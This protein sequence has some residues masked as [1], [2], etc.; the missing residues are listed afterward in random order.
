MIIDEA[1]I[2]E[3]GQELY[4]LVG[5]KPGQE[6]DVSGDFLVLTGGRLC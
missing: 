3:F 5:Y 1:E 4:D 2:Q 6:K